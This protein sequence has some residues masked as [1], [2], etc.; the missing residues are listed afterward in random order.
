[1]NNTIVEFFFNAKMCNI[2]SPQ[3]Y[4]GEVLGQRYLAMVWRIWITAEP[5]W[6]FF[7]WWK[8]NT[9][10]WFSERQK[11]NVILSI[12]LTYNTGKC[13]VFG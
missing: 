6:K 12:A 4:H 8:Y 7:L 5:E 1:M 9:R 2:L 10:L 13:G 11:W 3:Q